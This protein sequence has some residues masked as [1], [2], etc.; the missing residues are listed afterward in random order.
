MPDIYIDEACA[1]VTPDSKELRKVLDFQAKSM[2]Q[3]PAKP[4]KKIIKRFKVSPY[5]ETS[6][7]GIVGLHTYAGFWAKIMNHY[8]AQKKPCRLFD[9]RPVFPKPQFQK[10]HGF[11][12]KQRE[13]LE[14][15]L[16]KD[17]SGL[18]GAPTRY[19]KSTLIVNTCRAY[20]T[21]RT[22]I[23]IPGADLL[24]QSKDDFTAALPGREVVCIGTGSRT[25]F[26]GKDITICSMDS[27]HK[28]DHQDTQLIL[29]DEPHAL[30]TDS[31]LEEFMKFSRARK[32]G[33]GATLDGRFDKKDPLIVGAIGPILVNR[34]FLEGV[35]EGAICPLVIILMAIKVTADDMHRYGSREKAYDNL[36]YLSPQLQKFAGWC[37]DRLV[38]PDKQLLVFVKY[39]KQALWISEGIK[40]PHLVAVAQ[41]MKK[42]VRQDALKGMKE[43]TIKRC[44][45]TDIYSTG[46]TFSDLAIVLNF[47]GGGGN[48][49][50]IQ[51]P[52]RLAE[53]RPGKKWGVMLD[54]YFYV[55]DDVPP[56]ERARIYRSPVGGLCHDSKARY[57]AY[58]EKGYKIEVINGYAKAEQLI[59]ESLNAT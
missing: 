50:A 57:K 6:K 39:E 7:D 45:S 12:F 36:L 18:I 43:N 20:P 23:L 21:L 28:L 48:V 27:M 8:Q 5:N 42:K 11:R 4:W 44:V 49:T 47:G 35:A 55:A 53:I 16:S 15:A 59:N 10:M 31:R 54:P 46:V 13:L 56:E 19:G 58:K 34:T 40:S 2:E 3:D 24:K 41:L 51:K 38:A 1:F 9:L 33:F 30:V 32:L 37:C 25:K 29:I 22:V 17:C 26:Q 14:E 52:G